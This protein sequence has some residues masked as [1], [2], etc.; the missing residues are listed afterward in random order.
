LISIKRTAIVGFKLLEK[1][2]EI[3]EDATKLHGWPTIYKVKTKKY[4]HRD[5]P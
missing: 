2:E 1:Y 5:I 3:R 4:L